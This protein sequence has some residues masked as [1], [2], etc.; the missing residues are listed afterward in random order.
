MH[1]TH[2]TTISSFCLLS[3]G[4][5]N[6]SMANRCP[7]PL[8]HCSISFR[9]AVSFSSP[10]SSY[11]SFSLLNIYIFYIYY[12]Y[13][14]ISYSVSLISICLDSLS[15]PLLCSFMPVSSLASFITH[16]PPTLSVMWNCSILLLI[17][18]LVAAETK[19]NAA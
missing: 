6:G 12:I 13:K 3:R 15:P 5:R 17:G 19:Q 7:L 10:V 4:S 11:F 18:C 2:K 14:I 16:M 1:F 8:L 9:F